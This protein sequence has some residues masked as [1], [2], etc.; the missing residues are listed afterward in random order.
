MLALAVVIGVA[1]AAS[2]PAWHTL[3]VDIVGKSRLVATNALAQVAEF[4]GELVAPLAAGALIASLGAGPVFYLAGGL[5]AWSAV[6]MARIRAPSEPP[7][8]VTE[9]SRER[10]GLLRD[11]AAGLAYTVGA[12]V[13][14]LDWPVLWPGVV[15][16]H[17]IFHVFVLIGVSL[18]F[19]FIE[20]IE[21]ERPGAC[22]SVG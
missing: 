4:G 11:I 10:G 17:E 7:G 8:G 15:G 9:A 1:D 20:R 12:V 22:L 19:V 18:H 13:E 3:L 5:L 14:F 6:L 16:P 2:T 21:R